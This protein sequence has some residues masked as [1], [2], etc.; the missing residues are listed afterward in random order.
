[1]DEYKKEKLE[2]ESV[3]KVG[4]SLRKCRKFKI[5]HVYVRNILKERNIIIKKQESAPKYSAKQLES[6]RSLL[7]QLRERH[8][9][10]LNQNFVM[11][12]DDSYFT[13]DGSNA[14]N[15]TYVYKES[16][17]VTTAVKFE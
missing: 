7:R 8:L 2:S 10:P 4:Q 9:K 12:D 1:M 16:I 5:S 15:K 3:G 14:G 6:Q 13:L 11:M 17:C